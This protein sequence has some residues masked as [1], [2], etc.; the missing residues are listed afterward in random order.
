MRYIPILLIFLASCT[1]QQ[2][3]NRLIGNHPYLANTIYKDTVLTV[4]EIDTI[5]I[6]GKSIDTVFSFGVDTF[7]VSDSG[8]TVTVTKEIDRWRIKTVVDK[9]TI[10]VRDTVK[11]S[12]RDEVARFTVE[13]VKTSDIWKWRKQGALWWSILWLII[14]AAIVAIRIYLK[15][16]IPFLK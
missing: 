16:Q 8:L 11:V 5:F 9:Q 3:L 15:G 4:Y 14:I 6:D 12:Y 7:I 13:P 2:K 1:P 10:Y